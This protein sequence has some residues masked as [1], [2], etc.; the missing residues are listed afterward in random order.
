MFTTDP[1][2]LQQQV[3]AHPP[4]P[5]PTSYHDLPL[6]E[7]TKPVT[8]FTKP[9][10]PDQ[11]YLLQQPNLPGRLILPVAELMPL[12][13]QFPEV[14]IQYDWYYRQVTATQVDRKMS[15]KAPY[16]Y[17]VPGEQLNIFSAQLGVAPDQLAQLLSKLANS[18]I[19]IHSYT[20]A[21]AA[22]GLEPQK[23]YACGI[24]EVWQVVGVWTLIG[25]GNKPCATTS[26]SSEKH[27][28][29][30]FALEQNQLVNP[31]DLLLVYMANFKEK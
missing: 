1:Q 30:P 9:C 13:P 27:P 20:H 4:F 26:Y 18:P 29:M 8:I 5:V 15:I 24:F 2:L 10:L 19:P 14:Q 6:P 28:G 31:W 17:G 25:P 11:L 7:Q 12:D 21:T 22:Y 16:T 3:T 23:G